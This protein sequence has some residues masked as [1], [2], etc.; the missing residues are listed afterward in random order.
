[1]FIPTL[2]INY[3]EHI[4]LAKER[5]TKNNPFNGFFLVHTIK[6]SLLIQLLLFYFFE[7]R[8]ME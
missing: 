7:K 5:I 3:I 2:T 1:M 8:M 4:V 6:Y